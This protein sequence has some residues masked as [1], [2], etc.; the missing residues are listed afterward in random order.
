M[1]QKMQVYPKASR[2]P[3][4]KKQEEPHRQQR[5]GWRSIPGVDDNYQLEARSH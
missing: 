1:S 3:Q 4:E 5:E 2:D